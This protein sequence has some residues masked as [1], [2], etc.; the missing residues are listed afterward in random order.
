MHK[1]NTDVRRTIKST[2][3]RPRR[4]LARRQNTRDFTEFAYQRIK[5]LI[6]RYEFKPGQKLTQ[7]GLAARL[8]VSLTPVRE[9]LRILEKEGYA[10]PVRNR[11]FFVGEI[12]L[13][14]AEE[15]FEVREALEVLSVEK[16]TKYADETFLH[17]LDACTREYQHVVTQALT[18][19]RILM[20]Q[21]FHLLIARQADNETLRRTLEHVFERITLK[22]KIE[23]A[24]P[25]RGIVAYDEH[26]VILK[27][28]REG[29]VDRAR[30]LVGVHVRNAKDAV[31]RQLRE[32]Q[33]L[34][35]S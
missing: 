33:T 22:R 8:G 28:I 18:R 31:L 4:A 11:G 23:G 12:S 35:D 27:A 10:A 6:L 16:A 5:D 32:R 15:L 29:D 26:V 34:L 24:P 30:D 14:E 25:A 17:A 3:P 21:R 13:K 7:E 20:D 1:M 2:N 19:E 9:A